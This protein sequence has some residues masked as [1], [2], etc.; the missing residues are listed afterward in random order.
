MKYCFNITKSIIVI[1]YINNMK[2]NLISMDAENIFN[3]Q[4][5]NR[6]EFI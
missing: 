2:E 6:M 3:M 5:R 4:T 1:H